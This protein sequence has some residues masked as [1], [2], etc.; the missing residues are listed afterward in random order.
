M[1][2][3]IA[4]AFKPSSCAFPNDFD[5]LLIQLIDLVLNRYG[6]ESLDKCNK[7]VYLGFTFIRP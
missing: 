3:I 4:K 1:A 7:L 5:C 6:N 2:S